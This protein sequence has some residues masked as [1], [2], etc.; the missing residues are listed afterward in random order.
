MCIR[1][2][3]TE[4]G[5]EKVYVVGGNERS[6]YLSVPVARA[7]QAVVGQAQPLAV[8]LVSGPEGK[9]VCLLYTS[10]CV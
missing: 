5:A 7:V 6:D 10:R 1:D 3:L 2:R 4:Y 8:L 9:D